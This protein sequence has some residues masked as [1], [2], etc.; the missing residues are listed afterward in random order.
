MKDSRRSADPLGP[1]GLARLPEELVD[2]VCSFVRDFEVKD[3]VTTLG[4]LCLTSR[5]FHAPAQRALLYDPSRILAKRHV[6]H[7]HLFLNRILR[8]PE[9]G[10]Q[11]KRLEGLVDLFDDVPALSLIHEE[12]VAF[13]NW[14]MCLLRHCPTLEAVAVWP[15]VAAGWMAEL[16]K[17]PR[18][19]HLTVQGRIADDQ[20]LDDDLDASHS[21]LA[22]ARL[23]HLSSLTLRHLGHP[24][25]PAP[26]HL[27]VERLVVDKCD[28][29]DVE[30]TVDFNMVR[31]LSLKPSSPYV[32]PCRGRLQPVLESFTFQPK[33][34]LLHT[35]WSRWPTERWSD[36]FT[37]APALPNLTMVVLH[38]VDV[39]LEAFEQ[40]TSVAHNLQHI[41]LRDSVWVEDDWTIG[42]SPSP[43]DR[44]VDALHLLPRLRFLHLGTIP[45]S[46][47]GILDTQVYCRLHGVELEW[48]SPLPELPSLAPS[49]LPPVAGFGAGLNENEQAS[50]DSRASVSAARSSSPQQATSDAGDSDVNSH[51]SSYSSL[52]SSA[53]STASINRLTFPRITRTPSPFPVDDY[54]ASYSS[55][56]ARTAADEQVYLAAPADEPRLK[57]GYQAGDEADDDVEGEGYEPWHGWGEACDLAEADRAWEEYDDEGEWECVRE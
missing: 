41:E 22:S 28:I 21:F 11:V 52:S 47:D 12:P 29:F 45:T 25:D 13:L 10:K 57:R 20:Y 32:Y 4:S 23:D 1:H 30:L 37:E 27:P 15:D 46:A 42:F 3:A 26:V 7:A 50:R 40:V 24:A 18:V 48:R 43:D 17:L 39:D 2:L 44:L 55:T 8:H 16:D 19:R 14:A 31:H 54:L 34:P 9:L 49:P 36:F 5:Q 56:L 33:V 35:C 53:S 51:S 38:S 6:Q